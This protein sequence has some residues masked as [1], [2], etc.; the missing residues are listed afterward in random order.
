MTVP[1]PGQR[2]PA[3][4]IELAAVLTAAVCSRMFVKQTLREWK[5]SELTDPAELIVSELVT[6]AVRATGIT[7]RC[8]RWSALEQLQLIVVRIGI[9]GD[10]LLIE[11]WDSDPDLPLLQEQSIDAEGGRGLFLVQELSRRWSTHPSPGGG[12]VTWAELELPRSW[13]VPLAAPVPAPPAPSQLAPLP[14]PAP[15]NAPRERQRAERPG[16]PEGPAAGTGSGH[17]QRV[18]H[19]LRRTWAPET[20][21]TSVA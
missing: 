5:L 1:Q 3:T 16:A 11:V 21:S 17:L 4:E 2:P 6:N 8:P 12:K 19:R 9:N 14:A 20:G 18:Q 10:G 15:S 13:A 7:D